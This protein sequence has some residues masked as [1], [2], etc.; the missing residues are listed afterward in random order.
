MAD[1]KMAVGLALAKAWRSKISNQSVEQPPPFRPFV[2]S[3][4]KYAGVEAMATTFY[5]VSLESLIGVTHSIHSFSILRL[6]L[7][8][9]V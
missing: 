9:Y 2:S 7:V 5:L 8:H 3:E 1:L 6:R 4:L